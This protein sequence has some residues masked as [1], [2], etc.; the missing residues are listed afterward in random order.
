[1]ALAAALLLLTVLLGLIINLVVKASGDAI[2]SVE[3]AAEGGFDCILVLGAGVTA[4]N[5]PSHMLRDRLDQG[6]ALYQAQVA[7]KIIMSG[8]HGSK[9]Y[10]EV[11]VMKDYALAAGIPSEDVFMDH[12]GFSTYES[13]Y[14]SRDVFLAQRLVIVSQK[15]HLYR[16]LYVAEQLGLDA[17]GVAADAA[18]Y[19]GQGYREI[20]EIAARCKDFF[21]CL[22]SVKPTFLGEPIP[23][24]GNGDLTNDGDDGRRILNKGAVVDE[25]I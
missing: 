17:C 24:F 1:M 18:I 12:A 9:D 13:I 14:R 6:I 20:R 19:A 10:D 3:A 21:Y 22:L 25:H 8:D 11:S 5:M 16:A 2:I 15:Y 4:D 7:E 23:V